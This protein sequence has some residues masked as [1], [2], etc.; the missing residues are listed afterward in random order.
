MRIDPWFQ[1]VMLCPPRIL[2]R[3]LRPLSL[4]HVYILRKLD[5]P[6]IVVQGRKTTQAFLA[7]LM[8]CGQTMQQNRDWLAS[9]ETGWGQRK[10]K[11]WAWWINHWRQWFV[12]ASLNFEQYLSDY[13]ETP[14]H[15]EEVGDSG[16]P[17]H[18]GLRAPWEFHVHRI[19]CQ[20]YHMHPDEAWDCSLNLARAYF[21]C[22]AESNG[23]DSLVT[24]REQ[25]L[26]ELVRN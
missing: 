2:G 19:L 5:N 26:I 22:W 20:V 18:K 15:W 1:S 25:E 3:Q 12:V 11:W 17:T 7:A 8:I 16:N 4:G 10:L 23:D 14:E 13:T 21:D 6:Y 9:M 24:E